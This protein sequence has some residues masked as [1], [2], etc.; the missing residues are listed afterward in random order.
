LANCARRPDTVAQDFVDLKPRLTAIRSERG[1]RVANILLMDSQPYMADLISEG[2]IQQG[3]HITLVKDHDA[4][5]LQ[6]EEGIPDLL[7]IDLNAPDG[8]EWLNEIKRY[9]SRIPVLVVTAF[10]SLMK[11][12][13]PGRSECCVILDGP[14]RELKERVLEALETHQAAGPFS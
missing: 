8:Y 14:M 13:L 4:L 1:E 12:P 7:I 5:I 9:E 6:L 3:H 11:D 10:D 2:L